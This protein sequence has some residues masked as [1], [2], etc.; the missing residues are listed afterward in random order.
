MAK[1]QIFLRKAIK[2][3]AFTVLFAWLV[4]LTH[5]IVPHIH[6]QEQYGGCH[7]IVHDISTETDEHDFSLKDHDSGHEKVCHF[8]INIFQL[9]DLDN[10]FYSYDN[11]KLIT[12]VVISDYLFNSNQ[13][14]FFPKPETG[15]TSL[16]APPVL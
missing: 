5:S 13:E 10:L 1:Y 14:Q 7:D 4:I 12:P 16:R 3:K 6:V 8:A 15:I 2:I 11:T 9:A